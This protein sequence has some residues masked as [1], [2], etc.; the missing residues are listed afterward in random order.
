MHWSRHACTLIP[1]FMVVMWLF[2]FVSSRII[3]FHQ[4]YQN[5][6]SKLSDDEW[7]R[8]K[9]K[10]P[11]FFHNIKQ[12][13]DLCLKVE[14]NA[15][16][17]CAMVALGNVISA[18]YLCGYRSCGEYVGDLVRFFMTLSLPI[19]GTVLLL[20]LMCPTIFYPMYSSYLNRIADRRVM[21]LYNAPYGLP[22]YVASHQALKYPTLEELPHAPDT[23]LRLKHD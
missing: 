2:L 7:L 1:T 18:T 21:A 11:E 15:R 20:L 4:E 5:E 13:T 23:V 3:L 14:Q 12:H 6:L 9:C 8:V 17:S 10:D 19:L 16:K 22:H